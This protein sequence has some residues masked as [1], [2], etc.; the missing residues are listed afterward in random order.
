[1]N[2][3]RKIDQMAN[4]EKEPTLSTAI[5]AALGVLV[6]FG[7]AAAAVAGI[8]LVGGCATEGANA[9]PEAWKPVVNFVTNYADRIVAA[10]ANRPAGATS[11]EAGESGSGDASGGEP[12]AFMEVSRT[13]PVGTSP[14]P[15]LSWVYGGFNGSKAAE[16]PDAQIASLKVSASGLSYKWAKGGCEALGA[17]SK[18]DYSQTLACLFVRDKA[19]NWKGGK[20]DWISTSRTSRSFENVRDGYNGW[21]KDAIET[22]TAYGFL[23]ADKSGKRRTN[24][25]IAEK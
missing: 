10:Y 19:G 15:A 9:D 4:A 25:I 11:A 6:A 1:M 24:F 21:P 12:S 8:L 18:A 22:A 2:G 20:F 5:A 17:S 16:T 13:A 14:A 7:L 23:I 3:T